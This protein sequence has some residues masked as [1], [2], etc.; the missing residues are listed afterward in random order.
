[1]AWICIFFPTNTTLLL[2]KKCF[3]LVLFF[4]FPFLFLPQG[5]YQK[6]IDS[7]NI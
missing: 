3:F 5:I 7:V 4:L 2:L 6:K 1:M